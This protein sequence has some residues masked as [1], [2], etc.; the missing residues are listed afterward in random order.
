MSG[1][2]AK[3]L[4]R[5]LRQNAGRYFALTML[6]VLGVFLVFSIVGA[7]E[8]VLVGTEQQKSQ[9]LAS[10]NFCRLNLFVHSF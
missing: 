10:P 9:N 6:I 7:A 5:D 4:L 2:L 3:R 1:V 8:V